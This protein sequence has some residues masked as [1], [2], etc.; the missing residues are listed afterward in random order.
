MFGPARSS[1]SN[2]GWCGDARGKRVDEVLGEVI[3][4]GGEIGRLK[5]DA[6]EIRRDFKGT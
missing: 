3:I 4:I 5:P 6:Q 2:D 1:Y